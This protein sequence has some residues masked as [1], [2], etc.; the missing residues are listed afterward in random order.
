VSVLNLRGIT[1][2]YG[3]GAVLHG[4]DLTFNAGGAT[5]ILGRNGAG[6]TTIARTIAGLLRPSSGSVVLD[7][8]DLTKLDARRRARSGI[9][10]V[11]EGRG[12]FAEL[13]VKDNLRMGGF[14]VSPRRRR[15][16]TDAALELFPI[17]R[18]R[19]RQPAGNLSGGEQQM[20]AIARALIRDPEVL[21]LDEPTTGLAPVIIERLYGVFQAVFGADKIVVLI[22]QNA[23]LAARVCTDCYVIAN[24]VVRRSG[25]IDEVTGD[26]ELLQSYLGTVTAQN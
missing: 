23:A 2:G 10:L 5:A 18:E 6:K 26:A 12:V 21:I 20:L 14:P 8:R 19:Q 7:G 1:A 4:I 9:A 22:E 3:S 17:L 13:S 24:G 11:R 16:R 25:S 15:E